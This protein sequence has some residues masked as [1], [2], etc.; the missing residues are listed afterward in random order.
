ME[1]IEVESFWFICPG[2]ADELIGCEALQ[3]LESPGAI[4]FGD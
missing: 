4:V 2:F 3:G 1:W